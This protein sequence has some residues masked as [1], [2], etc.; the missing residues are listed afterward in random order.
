MIVAQRSSQ[1]LDLH[2]IN[3]EEGWA[4]EEDHLVIEMAGSEAEEAE[5]IE[6]EHQ[7]GFMKA[8]VLTEWIQ[9]MTGVTEAE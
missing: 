1:A 2:Q 8:S 7:R 9:E 6:I 3:D 5:D 4:A